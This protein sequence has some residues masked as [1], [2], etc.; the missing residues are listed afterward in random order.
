MGEH[1]Q[2]GEMMVRNGGEERMLGLKKCIIGATN[3]VYNMVE[4]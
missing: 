1:H 3:I 4:A 2:L